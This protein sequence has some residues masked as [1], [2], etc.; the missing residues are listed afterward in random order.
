MN[1]VDKARTLLGKRVKVT[2]GEE[3]PMVVLGVL[4]GVGQDGAFEID[5]GGFVHY[6]WPMLEIEELSFPEENQGEWWEK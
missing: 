3:G 2:L 5:D 1:T 6:C 4:L